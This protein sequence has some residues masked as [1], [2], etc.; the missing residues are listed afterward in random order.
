MNPAQ[1]LSIFQRQQ[2]AM[3]KKLQQ[4]VEMESPTTDKPSVDRFG[5]QVAATFQ[6]LGMSIQIDQQP[7]RGNH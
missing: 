7:S 6:D 1:T 5:E 4:W 2:D 3:L